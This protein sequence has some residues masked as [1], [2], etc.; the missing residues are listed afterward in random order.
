MTKLHIVKVTTA[1]LLIH[2]VLLLAS[3]GG[4][5]SSSQG[6]VQP[7]VTPA[8]QIFKT[9][10]VL[11]GKG[12]IKQLAVSGSTVFWA[13][14]DYGKGIW[15]YAKGSESVELL[16]PRL[17]QLTNIAVKGNYFYWTNINTQIKK[18]HL[19][20]TTL[21][22]SETTFLREV[23]GYSAVIGFIDETS[24][25]L[26]ANGLSPQAGSIE[27]ISLD[28]SSSQ[29]LYS[30][31]QDLRGVTVDDSFIYWL[32]EVPGSASTKANLYRI[33]KT[34]GLPETVCENIPRPLSAFAYPDNFIAYSDNSIFVAT[35]GKL[36]KVPATGG[37]F[38]VIAEG[39]NIQPNGIAANQGV[40]YW[41][42]YDTQQYGGKYSIL[43]APVA[44]GAV[45]VVAADLQE[46]ANFKATA[47]GLHWTEADPAYTSGYDKY[48]LLK[49]IPWATG[50]VEVLASGL[51]LSAFDIAGSYS[52]FTK[53]D[54][55]SNYGEISRTPVAGGAS[56]TLIG[57]VNATTLT[58]TATPTHLLIGDGPSLKKVPIGGGVTETLMINGRFKIGDIK[59]QDGTV[60]FTSYYIRNGIYKVSLAGGPYVALAEEIGDHDEIVSIQDGYVYYR[61]SQ[62]TANMETI[63][64]LRRV[65]VNGG[66]SESV[67]K[68]P[69]GSFFDAFEGIG[70]VYF[71][72]WIWNDQ[73]KQFKYDIVTGK[74]I[75]LWSG[76]PS[77]IGY[78]GTYLFRQDSVGN[79]Y[80]IP[81]N[82]GASKSVTR[83]PYPLYRSSSLV[84]SG[85]NFYYSITYLDE[86]QGYFTEIDFL[87]QLI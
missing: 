38:T 67:Y 68:L 64:E 18:I 13:D 72:E 44:G 6:A 48:R 19:Y 76:N 28:G 74:S 73:Y 16:T 10:P 11:S 87:E 43:A 78:N 15:K 41:L 45:S 56:E 71:R 77:F 36:L 60:F 49:K 39:Q 17:Y 31:S 66:P 25:Y 47:T 5:G 22:G 40:V 63:N 83:I 58:L 27:K 54:W 57:G 26:R 33:K 37:S 55:Y 61:L 69:Q 75:E 79:I 62:D 9:S 50:A 8:P 30:S 82:G 3:C 2:A 24:L 85:E 1:V 80:A 70:T 34:G 86:T 23:N 14:E 65:P 46:P 52:Y 29:T 81:K 84:K 21:D 42:N 35:Y 32:E 51:Y 4:G 7:P 12:Q 59:E 53:F 20:R